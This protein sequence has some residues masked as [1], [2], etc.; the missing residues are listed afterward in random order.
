MAN[1]HQL[2]LPGKQPTDDYTAWNS[3]G[4][5][6]TSVKKSIVMKVNDRKKKG[7]AERGREQKEEFVYANQRPRRSHFNQSSIVNGANL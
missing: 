2:F 1:C 7:R 3:A 5:Q 6:I 4:E